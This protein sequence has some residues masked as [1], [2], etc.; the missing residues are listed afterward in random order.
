M[1]EKIFKGIFPVLSLPFKDEVE[2]DYD[3]L[4]SLIDFCIDK[5]AQGLV[6]FGVASEFYKVNDDESKKIIN[7]VVKSAAG[8]VP[9]VV[10]VGRLSTLATIQQARFCEDAS[11]DGVVIFPP[12]FI[13]LGE[14]QLFKHYA[15]IASSIDLPIIIQDAPQV[16]GVT[17]DNDFF[18]G[19][20]DKCTNIKYAKLEGPFAGPKIASVL[21]ETGKRFKIFDGWGGTH[22]YEHL[23]RG[24]CGLMPG[25]SAVEIFVEIYKDFTGDRK[26]RAEENYR[27]I[28]PLIIL[29]SQQAE[30]FIACEK[31]MLKYRGVIKSSTSRNPWVTI[32][33]VLKELLINNLKRLIG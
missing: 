7:H 6:M 29:Q 27:N 26:E 12:Y 2:I 33:P 19:L 4:E 31:E 10:G 20:S 21:S 23:V 17:M 18:I 8:R 22:F 32:D 16:S 14:E 15:D 13:P 11:V 9:V 28:L 5:N 3:S 24:V 25:C 1:K 30:L